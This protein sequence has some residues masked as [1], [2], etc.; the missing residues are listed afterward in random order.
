MAATS[1][2]VVY[3]ALAANAGIAVIKFA[4]SLLTGS[5]ALLSEAIHSVV[6]V[7]QL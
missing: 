4:A 7:R 1:K 2:G 5:S 6:E 3:A